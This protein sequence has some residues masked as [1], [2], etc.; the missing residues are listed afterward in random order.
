[1]IKTISFFT[2]FKNTRLTE[3]Y[4]LSEATFYD[5]INNIYQFIK[6]FLDK[7]S[8]LLQNMEPLLYHAW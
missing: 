2:Q 3:F 8:R 6:P 7:M 1:M 4:M 5:S